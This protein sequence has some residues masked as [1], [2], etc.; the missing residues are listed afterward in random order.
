MSSFGKSNLTSGVDRSRVTSSSRAVHLPSHIRGKNYRVYVRWDW[1]RTYSS[2]APFYA[3]PFRLHCTM[4]SVLSINFL[5]AFHL[6]NLHD[7]TTWSI[8]FFR[9]FYLLLSRTLPHTFALMAC[10]SSYFNF[11]ALPAC[12]FILRN[13]PAVIYC[14]L[15]ANATGFSLR[16]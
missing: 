6:Y 14:R 9:R 10:L 16:S 5:W 1:C 4:Q 2:V 12:L 7:Q 8:Y 15:R 13:Q 3:I 11:H